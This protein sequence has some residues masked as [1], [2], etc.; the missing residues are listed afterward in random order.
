[1][2][3][4]TAELNSNYRLIKGKKVTEINSEVFV[5]EHVRTGARLLYIKNDDT[6]KVFSISFKT[7][8]VDDTGCPHIL[9]HS[10]LNG[11]KNFPAKNTFTELMKGSM[12]TFLNAFTASDKTSYP[13]ASTNDQDFF[14]LMHVYMDAVLYPNIYESP[15]VLKQE[16]WHHE[17]FKPEDEIVYRGVVYNEMKGAFSSP[18]VVLYR[19]NEEVQFPDTPYHFESGGDPEA[20]PQLTWEKFKAFHTRLYHPSNSWIFLYGDLDID[21]ALAF[22]DEKYLAAY[23]KTV[24]DSDIPLQKPFE[25]PL[26]VEENYSIGEDESP[27][28]KN[29]LS[30]NFTCSNVLDVTTTTTMSTLKQI[31]MD[32]PASP[33]KLAIQKSNLCADSFAYYDDSCLQPTFSIICKHV[34]DENIEPLIRLIYSELEKIARE[35]IDKKLIEALI[36][37]KEF[38]LREAEMG[39]FPKG[40]FYNSVVMKSWLH[41]GDPFSYLEFEPLLAVLR[42]GLAEPMFETMIETYLLKNNHASRIIMRPVKGL[43]HRNEAKV[44]AILAE[45]KAT[46][47][48]QQIHELV[49]DNHHLQEWQSVPDTPEDIAKIPFISLQ[50]I[51]KAAEQLPLEVVKTDSYTLLK[52]DVFTNGIVYLKAYLDISHLSEEELPWMALINE[53]I[54]SLDTENYSFGDISNEIYIHTG[55]VATELSLYM[56]FT[57]PDNIMPKL[58]IYSKCVLAKTEKML[59]LASELVFRTLFTDTVRI[60]QLIREQM[61]HIQM[62]FMNAGHLTAIRRMLG[63]TSRL[64]KWQDQTEGMAMFSFLSELEKKIST[65]PMEVSDRL[66][67]IAGKAFNRKNL[68]ISLISPEADIAGIKDKLDILVKQITGAD[69][70]SAEVKFTPVKNNEGIIAPV[71]IQYCAQGG[72]FMDLGFKYSGKMMVLENILRNDF[73]MQELRVKGGAYGIMVQFS[74]NGYMYFC[75]Y[76]DPNLAETLDTYGKVADYLRNFECSPRDFEKYII[77]TMS[78]LDRPYTPNLKGGTSDAHYLTNLT[79]ADRQKIRDEVLSTTIGDIRSYAGVV[80]AVM[81]QH[82]VAVFG[83]ETKI[84]ENSRLFDSLVPVIPNG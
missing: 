17:L 32:T 11:S 64:H 12:K 27:E 14:N 8:P 72:N 5:Y 3:A 53:L 30:F 79:Y 40:L 74:L 83:A 58:A 51:K 21:K 16:G 9:E 66:T 37:I 70:V 68:I 41:G 80:D 35:G 18:E 65:S 63:Q 52:H 60:H 20:I 62:G 59:T 33:L 61:S 49:Q 2:N 45:Y 19:K 13:I 31:L 39:G 67:R 10:V 22:I 36:N 48:E 69:T 71:N 25:K 15:D 56:D 76:R 38:S 1:M 75:S 82:Q 42:K 81:K 4:T 29:Y 84:R 23:E 43:V 34:L 6:N 78:T 47:S 54:G 26:L 73:L 50:D 24:P 46:L 7:P 28:G 77:G 57:N 44:A 55:G